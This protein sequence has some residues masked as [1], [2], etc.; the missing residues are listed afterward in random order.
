ME[1]NAKK[2]IRRGYAT[3]RKQAYV[4]SRGVFRIAEL[5]SYKIDLPTQC[6]HEQHS[7][8]RGNRSIFEDL[9]VF[10]DFGQGFRPK[11]IM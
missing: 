9:V 7:K 2:T 10:G 4:C 11:T 6:L 1:R 5:V 8:E 3:K